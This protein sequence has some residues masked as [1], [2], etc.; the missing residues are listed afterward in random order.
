MLTGYYEKILAFLSG[1]GVNIAETVWKQWEK[2]RYPLCHG[3]VIPW[4]HK[5]NDFAVMFPEVAETLW[6]SEVVSGVTQMEHSG[7]PKGMKVTKLLHRLGLLTDK[8]SAALTELTLPT[9]V[10]TDPASM[11]T[12]S[13]VSVYTSCM[14][15]E[16]AYPSTMIGYVNNPNVIMVTTLNRYHEKHSRQMLIFDEKRESVA[17]QPS[18]GGL[19]KYTPLL[20]VTSMLQNSFGYVNECYGE[21][22][23]FEGWSD[24]PINVLTKCNECDPLFNIDEGVC[25]VC[26]QIVTN[27]NSGKPLCDDCATD[28]GYLESQV[29]CNNCGEYCNESDIEYIVGYGNVCRACYEYEFVTCEACGVTL[30]SHDSYVNEGEL[31][32]EAC[33]DAVIESQQTEE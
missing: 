2:L 13:D 1:L 10:L 19:D 31:L 7:Y 3:S 18:Y 29:I 30:H 22:S 14:S 17:L 24:R 9:V 5:W 28:L 15:W 8:M 12:L 33:Y 26:G 20:G 16:G 4:K 25:P 21:V 23:I 11:I 6:Q 32:C 27:V